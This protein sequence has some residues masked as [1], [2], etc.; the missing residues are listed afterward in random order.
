MLRLTL[1]LSRAVTVLRL[2]CDCAVTAGQVMLD[3]DGRGRFLPR[4]TFSKLFEAK[5]CFVYVGV[6]GMGGFKALSRRA[7][8]IWE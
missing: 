6:P 2:C 4:A 3:M 7:G 1:W 5:V 8:D